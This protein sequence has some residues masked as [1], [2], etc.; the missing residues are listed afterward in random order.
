MAWSLLA[1]IVPGISVDDPS[2]VGKSWPEWWSVRRAL[3]EGAHR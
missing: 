3:L 1:L 2:V